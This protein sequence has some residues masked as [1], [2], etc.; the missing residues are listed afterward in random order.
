MT[1][2]ENFAGS[3]CQLII[4]MCNENNLHTSNDRLRV[5]INGKEYALGVVVCAC[6]STPV[7]TTISMCAILLAQ[8]TQDVHYLY[9]FHD[10]NV[11]IYIQLFHSTF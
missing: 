3:P 1:I 6:Y 5:D 11:C 2:F 10:L 8:I 7:S 4:S 9:L